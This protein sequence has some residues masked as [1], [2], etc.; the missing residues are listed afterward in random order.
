MCLRSG[1]YERT[2][3][4]FNK[5]KLFKLYIIHELKGALFIGYVLLIP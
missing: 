5:K 3:K 4:K 2:P 1:E